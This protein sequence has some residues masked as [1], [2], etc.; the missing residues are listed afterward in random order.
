MQAKFPYQS[1][2]VFAGNN[3]ILFIDEEGEEK[4]VYY[5]VIDMRDN[6]IKIPTAPS[7]E[8]GLYMRNVRPY[9]GLD[10][11]TYHDYSINQVTL[12]HE[13][14]KKQVYYSEP[15]NID[16]KKDRL[17]TIGPSTTY[18]RI[19]TGEINLN[20]LDNPTKEWSTIK[21]EGGLQLTSKSNAPWIGRDNRYNKSGKGE[22]VYVD[23]L[24]DL[25]GLTGRVSS[26]KNIKKPIEVIKYLNDAFQ[27]AK[28]VQ[29][30]AP[31]NLRFCKDCTNYYDENNKQQSPSEK[32]KQEVKD[33]TNAQGHRKKNP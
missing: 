15:F 23:D 20:F 32:E 21:F 8:N 14:G 12:I 3:P 11:Y 5:Y 30:I 16:Y 28:E 33:T 22:S 1:P 24:L 19:R 29:S 17:K 7:I 18:A 6:T 31:V 13:N 9:N 2:Y 4:R 10:Y 26:T 27:G 25:I